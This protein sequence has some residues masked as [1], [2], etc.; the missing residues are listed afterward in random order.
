MKRHYWTP[1]QIEALTKLYPNMATMQLAT[2]L[3]LSVDQVYRQ[4]NK[5]GLKKS[6]AFLATASSGRFTGQQGQRARFRKGHTPWNKGISHDVGGRS[7]ETRF[8]KG[9]KPHNWLPV[10]SERVSKDGYLQRKLTDTGYPPRDWKCIHLLI[11]EEHHGPVPKGHAVIFKDGNKRNLAIENLE[12][13][14]RRDLML[15]NSLHNYPKPI[16]QL[17]Q[18]RGALNRKINQRS[19]HHEQNDQ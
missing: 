6:E 17:I 11:W 18:L 4:A 14:S 8:A 3:R 1:L 19:R 12:C 9:S 15:R 16:A 13:I 5:L 7:K 10:G 2:I